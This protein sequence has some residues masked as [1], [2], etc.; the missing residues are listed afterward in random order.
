MK[1]PPEDENLNKEVLSVIILTVSTNILPSIKG[2]KNA[3]VVWDRLN[4]R[5]G[6]GNS[7]GKDY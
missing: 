1:T 4:E 3:R 2:A 7:R 6:V 5:Y